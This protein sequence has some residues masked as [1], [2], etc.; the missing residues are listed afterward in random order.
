MLEI[1]SLNVN[2]S[3]RSVFQTGDQEYIG[4]DM[5][6]G[7]DVDRLMNGHD[8]LKVFGP[9]SFDLVI[10]CETLEHDDMFWVTV[11]QMR[12]CT[13]PGGWMIITTPGSN[14]IKHNYPGDYYRFFE[15]AYKLF[16]TGFEET[17]IEEMSLPENTKGQLKPDEVHGYG[18]KPK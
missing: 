11:E 1:G 6:A 3:A 17:E 14:V 9:D 4:I 2:G 12:R 7:P 18:R 5:R 10:C 16:F 8:I 15:D 13:K